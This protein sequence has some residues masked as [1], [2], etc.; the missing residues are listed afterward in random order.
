ME[1]KSIEKSTTELEAFIANMGGGG[2]ALVLIPH[3]KV[4]SDN[5]TVLTSHWTSDEEE[6]ICFNVTI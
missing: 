2:E 3:H 1:R 4:T 5:D 6:T